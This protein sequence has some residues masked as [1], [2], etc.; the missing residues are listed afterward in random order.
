MHLE[1]ER[2]RERARERGREREREGESERASERERPVCDGSVSVSLS[3][4]SVSVACGVSSCVCSSVRVCPFL[5]RAYVHVEGKEERPF[6]PL[7]PLPYISL[8]PLYLSL[9]LVSSSLVWSPKKQK[10]KTALFIRGVVCCGFCE[11]RHP[12][13]SVL[14]P[15]SLASLPLP[16]ALPSAPPPSLRAR[17]LS[18]SSL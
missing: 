7:L 17:S 13:M 1:R 3:D 12:H 2:A 14:G 10:Q 18:L 8:C 11:Q 4:V 6:H 16:R 5:K 15:R 9:T